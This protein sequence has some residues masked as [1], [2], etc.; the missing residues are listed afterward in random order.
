[1]SYQQSYRSGAV[2]GS[3]VDQRIQFLRKTYTHLAGAVGLFVLCSWFLYESGVSVTIFQMLA[4]SPYIWLIILGAFSLVGY[5][6]QAMARADRPLGTQYLGLLLYT[7]AEAL[8]FSPLLIATRFYP[9]VLVDAAVLTI[10]VFT[11]LTAYV[12]LYNKD[13]SY[14]GGILSIAGFVALGIIVVGVLFGFT[15]GIWFSALMVVFAA[16]ATLF[17]TSKVLKYYRADQYVGA[18]LELFAA[19]ALMFWY[20]LQVLMQL[21]RR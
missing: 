13:F 19:I 5:M 3:T 4:S 11:G 17:S 9:G 16:G 18:A 10:A 15:L 7:G 14:L 20:V 1:M 2:Y 8:I 21:Q 6:A 12:L